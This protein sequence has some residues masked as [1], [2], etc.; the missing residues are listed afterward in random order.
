M[1]EKHESN[2]SLRKSGEFCKRVEVGSASS[3]ST[4]NLKLFRAIYDKEGHDELPQSM[5]TV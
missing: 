2:P 3:W 4:F 1:A 5:N